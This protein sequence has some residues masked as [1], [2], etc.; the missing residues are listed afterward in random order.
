MQ[1]FILYPHG[2][3]SEVQRR[4]MT[5]IPDANIHAV[6]VDGTFDDCQ[7]MVKSL[8]ADAAFKAEHKLV[9]VN[10]INWARILAQVVYYFYAALR[11][12][13]PAKAVS[14]SVPTGNFGD[15]YAGYIAKKMGLPIDQLIIAT[16]TNDI[17]T[18]CLKAGDY[19]M[20]GVVPT[21]SPSMDI[22][23]SSNFE[24]V[25]YDLYGQDAAVIHDLMERFKADR[26][27]TL[28][29]EVYRQLCTVFA[30]ERV[31]DT[32][33]KDTIRTV[34]QQTG[35]LLDPH[36][37]IGVKAGRDCRKGTAPLVTLA[38]AHPAKFPDAVK[39]ASG[40]TPALPEH[41]QDL[42]EREERVLRVAADSEAVKACISEHKK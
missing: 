4:Q 31:D 9:A 24:R 25:L 1:S 11:L 19:T 37:A 26:S 42:F 14:F 27:I 21:I 33:T 38:T 18:R 22:Q 23:I 34:Y 16:N 3:I 20:T 29:P 7:H 30:A 8:F 28:A 32:Q 13:A 6:A 35:E 5:T 36:S 41:L 2:R 12:G 15:I 17:L 10:S 39:E 40:V